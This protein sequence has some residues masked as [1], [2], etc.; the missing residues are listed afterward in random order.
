MSPLD[1]LLPAARH[2]I[3]VFCAAAAQTVIAAI[4]DA[5]GVTGLDYATVASNT[6]NAAAVATAL[7]MGAL[8]LT[9][10]THQYGIGSDKG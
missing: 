5:Q 10:L 6:I 4:I 9:P 3:I 1:K 2:A 7:A 8:Y